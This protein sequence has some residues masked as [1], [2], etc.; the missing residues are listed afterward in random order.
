M[1]REAATVGVNADVASA[2][3]RGGA[4]GAEGTTA[5]AVT[6]GGDAAIVFY[7]SKGVSG[8]RNHLV[9]SAR[10]LAGA[11]VAAKAPRDNR[12]VVFEGGEGLLVGGNQGVAGAGGGIGLPA[13]VGGVAPHRYRAI[14]GERREG[15]EV[16]KLLAGG[17]QGIVAAEAGARARALAG[18]GVAGAPIQLEKLHGGARGVA[19]RDMDVLVHRGA[20]AQLAADHPGGGVEA[21]A[22]RQHP[23]GADHQI[24][25]GV[26][27]VIAGAGG[28]REAEGPQRP[29]GGL[30]SGNSS[31]VGHQYIVDPHL[32]A[33]LGAHRNPDG[34]VGT[35]TRIQS[36]GERVGDGAGGNLL[37]AV[38]NNHRQA[39]V[40]GG[41]AGL[42][43]EVDPQA[44]GGVAG[45][46]VVEADAAAAYGGAAAHLVV[47]A[48]R[49]CRG[50]LITLAQEL[51]PAGLIVRI[52]GEFN[53]AAIES[54]IAIDVG[55]GG[56]AAG[57]D[58]RGGA[59]QGLGRHAVGGGAG[60]AGCC[61][62][63][64]GGHSR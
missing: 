13:A 6:P 24:L 20:D 56:Q 17:A 21:Q 58:Q 16:A 34:Q 8:G 38:P 39:G 53:R 9:A 61:D 26:E 64:G 15:A 44:L 52:L 42:F 48:G 30:P 43:S 62:G 59:D 63:D 1:G 41:G 35:A 7:G 22:R 10:G 32:H 57:V 29:I 18:Q 33:P 2:G 37:S 5:K 46:A 27:V 31:G 11:A 14:V 4:S 49:K 28:A 36:G 51:N 47:E 54:A 3:G 12:A 40:G 55:A 23:I 45:G 19:G 50:I 25:N 60:A